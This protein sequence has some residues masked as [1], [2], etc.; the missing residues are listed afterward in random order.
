MSHYRLYGLVF[1]P[2]LSRWSMVVVAFSARAARL[3][4]AGPRYMPD[5][6]FR[7]FALASVFTFA[8]TFSATEAFGIFIVVIV[9][10][11]T[12]VLRLLWHRWLGGVDDATVN[13]T[14]AM[15]ELAVLLLFGWLGG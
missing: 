14:A 5:L 6:T 10:A 12:V 3:G 8:V 15:T 4:A 11:I 7:E 13:A 1:A 2:L 9:A